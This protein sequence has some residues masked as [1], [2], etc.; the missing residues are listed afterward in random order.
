MDKKVKFSD[1]PLSVKIMYIA[2]LA[3][4]V[5][6]AVVVTVVSVASR[7]EAKAPLTPGTDI[8]GNPDGGEVKE[9]EGEAKPETEDKKEEKPSFKSPVTG[10]VSKEHSLSETVFSE[11]LKEWRTHSGID[12]ATAENCAV[13]AAEKGVV[14]AIYDDPFHGRTV[15][16]THSMN[17]KT[18]YSNLAKEDAAFVSVGD[19][20]ASGDRIGTVGYTAIYE[21]AEDPHLHFEMKANGKDL[22]PLAHITKESQETS[23]GI[24]NESAA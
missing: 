17:Y 5:I 7:R 19:T 3:I 1:R 4:L 20:V 12:I 15:E 23:L 21:I 6:T 18:I 10:T 22:D 2:T 16:L 11:T 24:K 9:P 8:S 13:Y 14:S